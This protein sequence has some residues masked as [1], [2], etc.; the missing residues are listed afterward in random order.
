MRSPLKMLVLDS[1]SSPITKRVYNLG[2][3]RVHCL[4]WPGAPARLH[5]G[6][7]ERMAGRP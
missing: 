2:A 6:R 3:G 4:V 1:I 5:Q 7:R